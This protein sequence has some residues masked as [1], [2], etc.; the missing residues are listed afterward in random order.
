MPQ[1]YDS[2]HRR[3][4][5]ARESTG[6]DLYTVL[7]YDPIA[8]TCDIAPAT[9]NQRGTMSAVP[10]H[11]AFGGAWENQVGH[12]PAVQATNSE[13][14]GNAPRGPRW[15]QSLPIQPGDVA[16]VAYVAESMSD[17][18]I[19]GFYRWRGDFGLPWVAN[20][21]L[22]KRDSPYNQQLPAD[23]GDV[24]DRYDLLLPS[25]AWMRSGNLGSWT[26]ATAPVHL[27]KAWFALDASGKVR[28]RARSGED[29]DMIF[30]LDAEAKTARLAV[31][32][33]DSSTHIEIKQDDIILRA[34]RD[35]LVFAE[36]FKVDLRKQDAST[37]TILAPL[38]RMRPEDI[39]N[40]Q[41]MTELGTEAAGKLVL[42]G[43]PPA[44]AAT[45][46]FK[47]PLLQVGV[48]NALA[49]IAV[50]GNPLGSALSG[51]VDGMGND[52]IA[53][54]LTKV[55]GAQS[56]TG[57]LEEI[58]SKLDLGKLSETL[59]IPSWVG[60]SVQSFAA[61][62]PLQ[63]VLGVTGGMNPREMIAEVSRHLGSNIL[64]GADPAAAREAILGQINNLPGGLGAIIQKNLPKIGT[65]PF[66]SGTD[67]PTVAQRLGAH[68][69]E[70]NDD[71]AGPA[72]IFDG[73]NFDS[74]G[75]GADTL[76]QV[77]AIASQIERAFGQ[78]EIPNVTD[79][80]GL[81]SL[82]KLVDVPN[83]IRGA[84]ANLEPDLHTLLPDLAKLVDPSKIPDLQ[85]IVGQASELLADPSKVFQ[86]LEN[87]PEEL[88]G[89]INGLPAN[90]I[91]QVETLLKNPTDLLKTFANSEVLGEMS[92]VM[93]QLPINDLSK[94]GDLP[95]QLMGQLKNL[96][97]ESLAALMG[98][99]SAA[100]DQLSSL[101]G[102]LG[103]L[104]D[105]GIFRVRSIR[106]RQLPA[107]A[108][109]LAEWEAIAPNVTTGAPPIE[110]Y[111]EY[112]TLDM[113]DYWSE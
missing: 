91:P 23:D 36:K 80:A 5:P 61:N 82:E 106:Q 15:G 112:G 21:V 47:S 11:C 70:G 98:D 85:N 33:L 24:A 28:I 26:M 57:G 3:V 19:V 20:Q 10:I 76:E 102:G 40:P 55:I 9:M 104:K 16:R 37:Q 100:I 62:N 96:K 7:A 75:L 44:L 99:P 56:L 59:N 77:K 111:K 90:L 58:T 69:L 88:L 84:I 110:R 38:T 49:D 97:P 48:K 72:K 2:N 51:F 101:F 29:Y 65:L 14:W 13:R 4:S 39:A 86:N 27:P 68:I 64:D 35:V 66:V 109:P 42:A 50:K 78:G 6:S 54:Q 103:G 94:I 81:P 53:S 32:E 8:Q 95:K 17:P 46:L 22:G 83:E 105:L 1:I 73:I 113:P 45:E 34:K 92:Q 25:G 41:K 108:K 107:L 18:V 60:K 31:G 52:A 87:L 30:E 12:K 79:M 93:G 67:V 71:I 63:S 43:H 89:Q 74:L